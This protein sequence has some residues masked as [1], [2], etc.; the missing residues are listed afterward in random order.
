MKYELDTKI[1][2]CLYEVLEAKWSAHLWGVGKWRMVLL[3]LAECRVPAASVST[4][5][6]PVLPARVTPQSPVSGS[7]TQHGPVSRLA[8]FPV[9]THVPGPLS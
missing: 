9:H 3:G 7:K 2:S 8:Q 5:L 6:G 4:H 1:S